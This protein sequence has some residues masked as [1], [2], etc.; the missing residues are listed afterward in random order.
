MK[1]IFIENNENIKTEIKRKT[2]KHISFFNEINSDFY[3]YIVNNKIDII[4]IN[5]SL[6]SP[7]NVFRLLNYFTFINLNVKTIIY[8]ENEIIDS[9][10]NKS[11]FINTIT[12]NSFE[13]DWYDLITNEKLN[14]GENNSFNIA[15]IKTLSKR[16]TQILRMLLD[17]KSNK[18]I[19]ECI[20]VKPSLV[21]IYK[22]RIF[23]KLKINSIFEIQNI[24]YFNNKDLN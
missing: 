24:P 14:N 3:N 1:V 7:D 2:E 11:L 22:K 17:G 13:G 10:N 21:S 18:K 20:N 16:E 12:L 8:N 5:C 6:I 15:A 19:C 9:Q 4:Y 23:Y